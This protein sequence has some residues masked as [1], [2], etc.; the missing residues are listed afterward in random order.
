MYIN[1]TLQFMIGALLYHETFDLPKGIMFVCV[2][3]GVVLFV[4]AGR[5]K[6]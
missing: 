6:G 5:E 4:S 3:I 2:W 1:P